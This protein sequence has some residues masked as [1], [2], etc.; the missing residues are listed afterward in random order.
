MVI[1]FY[2]LPKVDVYCKDNQPKI[3]AFGRF[4]GKKNPLLPVKDSKGFNTL[5]R[6]S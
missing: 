3:S 5:Q 1:V 4:N 6:Y 2:K